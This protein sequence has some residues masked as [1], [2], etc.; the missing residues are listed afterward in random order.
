MVWYRHL[1]I[2]NGRRRKDSGQGSKGMGALAARAFG[3][4]G[5]VGEWKLFSKR[6]RP[7][8]GRLLTV[9]VAPVGMGRTGAVVVT[10]LRVSTF[11]GKVELPGVDGEMS[12]TSGA[13]TDKFRV[14]RLEEDMFF[15]R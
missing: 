10:P 3:E 4:P 1:I 6:Y 11:G 5:L 9:K 7:P 13:E 12:G 2:Q 14:F 15:L 8:V